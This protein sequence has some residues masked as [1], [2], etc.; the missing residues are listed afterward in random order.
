MHFI[1]ISIILF[2]IKQQKSKLNHLLVAWIRTTPYKNSFQ[3]QN[4]FRHFTTV[5]QSR[6]HLFNFSRDIIFLTSLLKKFIKKRVKC[7][8]TRRTVYR[9]RTQLPKTKVLNACQVFFLLC[10]FISTNFI[11]KYV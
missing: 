5:K 11:K 1:P 4:T 9:T 7:V 8:T 10:Q 3:T 2:K 6:T